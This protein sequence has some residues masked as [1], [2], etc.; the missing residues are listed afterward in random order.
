MMVMM[1]IPANRGDRDRAASRDDDNG[2]DDDGDDA[3]NRYGDDDHGGHLCRIASH[4]GCVYRKPYPG[5]LNDR[6]G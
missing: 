5:L 1:I 2:G 6:I 4:V 3:A